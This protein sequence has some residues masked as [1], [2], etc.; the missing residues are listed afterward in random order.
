[1]RTVMEDTALQ[2]EKFGKENGV[3]R[4]G[5]SRVVQ[6]CMTLVVKI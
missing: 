6:F 1:M 4:E 3:A 5:C 2:R